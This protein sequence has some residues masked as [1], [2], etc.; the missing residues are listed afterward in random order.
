MYGYETIGDIM[1]YSGVIIGILDVMFALAVCAMWNRIRLAIQLTK[2]TT[3]AMM[4]NWALFFYP[5]LPF[6]VFIIY[7][8]YWIVGGLYMS[9]VIVEKEWPFPLG[10]LEPY[11]DG[12]PTLQSKLDLPLQDATYVYLE[13]DSMWEY[14][15]LAHFFMLLWMTNFISYHTYMVVAGVYAEWYFADWIDE[16]ETRKWR[17]SDEDVLVI[18]DEII[19]E[20]KDLDTIKERRS[21]LH[22][23]GMD[24][25]APE[26][27]VKE[28]MKH[29]SKLS[30]FPVCAS[31]KRVTWYHL[32]TIAF[33]SL[34]IAII[35]FI[36]HTLTYF[37]K[38][39]INS[40]PS[41][42]Q[43]LILGIIKCLLKCI[44]C[45]LNRINRNGLIITSI[46]GWPFCAASMKGIVIILKNVVRARYVP[47]NLPHISVD[48]IALVI[49]C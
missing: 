23:A 24:Q 40:E 46:Y 28:E 33:G 10:Y 22:K 25:N 44:K 17:G 19:R 43:K 20:E 12:G 27:Q 1:W 34:L 3:R 37:E 38:K 13:V 39:F 18:G 11:Y 47:L 45:I 7:M 16:K 14:L 30:R 29:I 42:I 31:F 48:M 49:K 6:F 26:H 32:G 8:I 41:P 5:L 15:G 36:E 2:E 21:Q 9:S 4:T 35:E